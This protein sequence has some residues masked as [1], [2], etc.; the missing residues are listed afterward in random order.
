MNKP[1]RKSEYFGGPPRSLVLNES[2]YARHNTP[3]FNQFVGRYHFVDDEGR[4]YM[5][6]TKSNEVSQNL[7]FQMKK[8][9]G[10]PSK[11][12][13]CVMNSL[14][15]IKL[16]VKLPRGQAERKWFK[17]SDIKKKFILKYKRDKGVLTPNIDR[18]LYEVKLIS[19]EKTTAS[20]A[21]G[22][23]YVKGLDCDTCNNLLNK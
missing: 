13:K 4:Q 14:G 7:N 3:T 18:M 23:I 10:A 9:K 20:R 15:Y 17:D 12:K 5:L 11:P 2:Y 21:T 19:T 1:R 16:F 6:A 22:S 8:K